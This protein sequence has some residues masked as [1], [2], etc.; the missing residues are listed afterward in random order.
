MI[1][2]AAPALIWSQAQTIYNW[3]T[4]HLSTHGGEV[5]DGYRKNR[6]A[7]KSYTYNYGIA[8]GAAPGQR[9]PYVGAECGKFL[10]TNPA[11]SSASVGGYDIL[12]NY[13]Q[14]GGDASGFNDI[15]LPLV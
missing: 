5:Y 14:G 7:H 6:A 10:M 9:R 8:V 3:C 11:Y 15:G 1:V 12:P 2:T 4:N 13:G